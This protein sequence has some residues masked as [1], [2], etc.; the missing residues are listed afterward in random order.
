MIYLP[1]RLCRRCGDLYPLG[2]TR[3]DKKVGCPDCGGPLEQV[4][5]GQL[6]PALIAK[7]RGREAEKPATITQKEAAERLGVH[8][9]TVATMLSD[10]RLEP[11]EAGTG[12]GPHAHSCRRVAVRSLPEG[13]HG[14]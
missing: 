3:A 11:V 14:R 5:A 6:V 8:P 13:E 10:G 1:C 12:A 7:L 2:Y 4:D 9:N